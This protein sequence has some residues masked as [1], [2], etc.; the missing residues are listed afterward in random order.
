MCFSGLC[1]MYFLNV[2]STYEEN[3]LLTDP[4]SQS[5]RNRSINPQNSFLLS[6]CCNAFLTL[7]SLATTGLFSTPV[8]V[9]FP[10]YRINRIL[11]YES[12]GGW[13]L[14][15]NRCTPS[16]LLHALILHSSSLLRSHQNYFKGHTCQF[17]CTFFPS[18]I[19]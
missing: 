11:Y 15:L 2:V 6:L 16:M 13:L 3:S 1:F 12:F 19:E 8:V 14:S 18:F 7:D 5:I 17:S 4:P 10:E 9:P